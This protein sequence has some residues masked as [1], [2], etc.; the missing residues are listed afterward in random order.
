M[1]IPTVYVLMRSAGD[2]TYIPYVFDN[3]QLAEKIF[4]K[5]TEEAEEFFTSRPILSGEIEIN[6]IPPGMSLTKLFADSE[7]L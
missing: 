5:F 3:K 6:N 7:T 4:D 1:K 2:G